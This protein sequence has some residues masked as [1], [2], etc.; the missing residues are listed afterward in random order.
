M[1]DA[2]SFAASKAGGGEQAKIIR[3]PRNRAGRPT[4]QGQG[5][6][7]KRNT[8]PFVKG[9]GKGKGKFPRRK[10]DSGDG[11]KGEED[12]MGALIEQIQKQQIVESRP[13]PVRY[14]PQE[15]S[16]S[17]LKVMWPRIP[18]DANAR[19]AAVY[20]ELSRRGGRIAGGYLSIRE[21]GRRLYEKRTTVFHSETEKA[22]ALEEANRLSKRHAN[23]HSRR[24]G[25]LCEP[26]DI[27]FVNHT[28]ENRD[29]QKHLQ[30][31]VH[32]VYPNAGNTPSY[33]HHELSRAQER[34]RHNATFTQHQ[35][36]DFVKKLN[37]LVNPEQQL[38]MTPAAK[39][40][41]KKSVQ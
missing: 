28:P 26:K 17:S 15:I 40:S 35:S 29:M 39:E 30:P 38:V 1:F 24:L 11:D 13:T 22:Q 10:R 27:S 41:P 3:S 18:T 37:D 33:E 16:L 14:E 20:Q 5:Q 4:G 34:L 25:E 19:S 32:G 2:R 31:L 7:F 12:A 6:P 23:L 8:K 21:L 36:Q 9:K